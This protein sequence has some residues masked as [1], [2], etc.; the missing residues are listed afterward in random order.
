MVDEKNYPSN[1][2][3]KKQ[4]K[5]EGSHKKKVDKVVTGEAIQRKKPLGSR[6]KETFTGEDARSVGSY[7]LFDVF[8][9]AAKAMLADAASQG[10]ERLLFGDSSPRTRSGSGRSNYTSYNRMHSSSSGPSSRR[11]ISYRARATHDFDEIVVAS[12]GEAEEVLDRL[13]DLVDS[14]DV[15]S[16][17]DFYDLVGITGNFTD[18]KWGWADLRSASVRRV[19]DGYLISLPKPQ[20]LD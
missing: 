13:G 16:V 9:P 11:E 20:P 8:V 18:D 5:D 17:A 2:N 12:R 6:I 15:A 10:A 7:I 4:G 3:S 19:R 14:Y 1:S